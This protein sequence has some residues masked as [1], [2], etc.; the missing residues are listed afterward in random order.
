MA[1]GKAYAGKPSPFWYTAD[2]MYEMLQ[3]LGNQ[4]VREF[5]SELDGCSGSKAGKIAAAFRGVPC[6]SLTRT[7]AAKLLMSARDEAR[8]V[9]PERL[10]SVGEYVSLFPSHYAIS[11]GE[12][13]IGPTSLPARVPFVVEAWAYM[14]AKGDDA[15]AA[16]YVNRTPVPGDISAFKHKTAI[17]LYGCGLSH[18]FD[19]AREYYNALLPDHYRRKRTG[20]FCFSRRDYGCSKTGLPQSAPE[21]PEIPDRTVNTER[22]HP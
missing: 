19:I 4:P 9:R 10:G 20:P 3:S 18:E 5:I 8:P 12:V 13:S 22:H 16:F 21:Y 14:D 2:H 6:R 17:R 11:R 7:D 15:D 1:A